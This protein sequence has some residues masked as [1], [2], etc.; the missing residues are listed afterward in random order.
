M[1]DR[2]DDRS[3]STAPLH[4]DEGARLPWSYGSYGRTYQCRE[5]PRLT[6]QIRRPNRSESRNRFFLV[7][8]RVITDTRNAL[9]AALA[10]PHDV[11]RAAARMALS[12][13]VRGVD[14]TVEAGQIVVLAPRILWAE[15]RAAEALPWEGLPVTWR[16]IY[17]PSWNYYAPKQSESATHSAGLSGLP[18]GQTE[19]LTGQTGAGHG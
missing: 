8:G 3:I 19:H 6:C 18:I 2:V 14:V 17:P 1:L 12:I 9:S 10:L 5:H 15:A 16:L 4:W 7:D 13:Q 11:E